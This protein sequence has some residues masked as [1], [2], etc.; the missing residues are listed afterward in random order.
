M[1]VHVDTA[2]LYTAQAGYGWRVA[3][4]PAAFEKYWL[5]LHDGR[6]ATFA[7]AGPLEENVPSYL[8]LR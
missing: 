4:L 2:L 8:G 5:S 3:S 6:L 7:K 1:E